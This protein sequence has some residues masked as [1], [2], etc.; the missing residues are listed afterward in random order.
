MNKDS[1]SQKVYPFVMLER[2]F[3]DSSATLSSEMG[4]KSHVWDYIVADEYPDWHIL[5][6]CTTHPRPQDYRYL[7]KSGEDNA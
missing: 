7:D 3:T 4:H 6:Y 5:G 1:L 2:A